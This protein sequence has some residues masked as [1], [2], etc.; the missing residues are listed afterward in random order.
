MGYGDFLM[1]RFL[2]RFFQYLFLV[3]RH[4]KLP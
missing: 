3:L 2:L 4:T 1:A